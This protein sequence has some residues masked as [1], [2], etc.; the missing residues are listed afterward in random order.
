MYDVV[1]NLNDGT[2]TIS[3]VFDINAA[4]GSVGATPYFYQPEDEYVISFTN[5]QNVTEF[6][7]I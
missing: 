5:L 1:T 4:T 2:I 3:D 6:T 7:N